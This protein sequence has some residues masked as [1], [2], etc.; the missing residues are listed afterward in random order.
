VSA[1]ERIAK[2]EALLARVTSR[3][4]D[5]RAPRGNGVA[6]KV[7]GPSLHDTAQVAAQAAPS[8]A[9]ATVAARPTAAAPPVAV[10][11]PPIRPAAVAPAPAPIPIRPQA[12]ALAGSPPAAAAA[13]VEHAAPEASSESEPEE[14]DIDA[15]QLESVRPPAARPESAAVEDPTESRERLVAAPAVDEQTEAIHLPPVHHE[16]APEE[17]DG[18]APTVAAADEDGPVLE[19]SAD[20]PDVEVSAAEI[21]VEEPPASSRRP[22]TQEPAEPPLEELAFGDAAAPALPHAPPPESGRQ[23]ALTQA[24]LDFESEA[25]GVRSK[26][27][28]TIIKAPSIPPAERAVE[29]Q[30]AP[31]ADEP[32]AAR[33]KTVPP[34]VHPASVPPPSVPAAAAVTAVIPEVVRPALGALPVAEFVGAPRAFTPATFGD[35]LDATLSL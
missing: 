25:T 4:A 13:H 27:D 19:L 35:L 26:P 18:R 21:E 16:S 24:D 31:R 10:E 14:L 34:S 33:P 29:R 23:V 15:A 8:E 20:S 28:E 12:P 11:A 1:Q 9:E 22:I 2:L 3:A 6:A 17:G 5:A 7:G 30:D 32:A